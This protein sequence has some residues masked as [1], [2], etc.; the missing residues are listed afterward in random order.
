MPGGSGAPLLPAE[1]PIIEQVYAVV[2]KY[3]PE[4]AKQAIAKDGTWQRELNG[5]LTV[6]TV[7][8]NECV[9]VHWVED[10]AYCAIQTAYRNGELEGYEKPISCHLYPIRIDAMAEKDSYLIRYV[11]LSDFDP[12]RARGTQED[13]HLSD[14]LELPLVRALGPERTKLLIDQLKAHAQD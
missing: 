6:Q 12:A 5:E 14:F 3:L 11:I 2:E 1:V 10:I 13:I 8:G 7:N 4:K 9:F